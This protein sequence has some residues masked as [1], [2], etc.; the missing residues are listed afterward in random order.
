M[1]TTRSELLDV[2]YRFYPRGVQ[3]IQRIYVPPNEP[4]Y[5][6]TE[7]HRRLM[8]ATNRGRA[9]YPTWKAMIRRLGDRSGQARLN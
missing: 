2:I 9:E 8:E 6:D 4:V 5:A 1:K 3:K 7:E